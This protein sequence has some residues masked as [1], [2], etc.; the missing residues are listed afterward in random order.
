M[1]L[2]GPGSGVRGPAVSINHW[3]RRWR[4]RRVGLEGGGAGVGRTWR[5]GTAATAEQPSPS[6][7]GAALMFAAAI[8][9]SPSPHPP[10]KELVM[11]RGGDACFAL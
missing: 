6:P 10:D 7:G 5:L 11:G 1:G 4:R 9:Q 8:P 3:R 2:A